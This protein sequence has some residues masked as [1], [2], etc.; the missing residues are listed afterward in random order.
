MEESQF[1]IR[2]AYQESLCFFSAPHGSS[3][4]HEMDNLIFYF[5]FFLTAKKDRTF[6]LLNKLCLSTYLCSSSCI[7]VHMQC[8]LS[9]SGTCNNS[10]VFSYKQ[11]FV[12]ESHLVQFWA[13]S[14]A[15]T[16][17]YRIQ[18]GRVNVC[19]SSSVGQRK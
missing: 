5:Y 7:Y 13:S 12:F 18:A 2:S 10:L 16:Y 14:R 17:F 3:Q 11:L 9:Y 15:E 8:I 4:Y 19:N 1:K 6:Q